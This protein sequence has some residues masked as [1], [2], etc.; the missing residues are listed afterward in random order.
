MMTS[1]EQEKGWRGGLQLDRSTVSQPARV[2]RIS[3]VAHAGRTRHRRGARLSSR[4]QRE[5]FLRLV[6]LVVAHGSGAAI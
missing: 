6:L 1:R 5:G 3:S 4:A 2:V